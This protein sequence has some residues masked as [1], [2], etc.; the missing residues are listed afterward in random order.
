MPTI[1]AGID[2]VGYGPILGPLVVASSIFL[3]KENPETNMWN[4]LQ[5]SVGKSKKGLENRILVCDSKKAY[6]RQIGLKHLEQTVRAFMS[7]LLPEKVC[8]SSLLPLLSD[9]ALQVTKYPW[10]PSLYASCLSETNRTDFHAL[11][12]NMKHE[13]F[14][15]IDFRSCCIDVR[16]F[17]KLIESTGNKADVVINSVL[18]LIQQI[19]SIAVFCCAKR[20]IIFSDRL[21]GRMYYEEMIN[22]L[23]DVKIIDREE[24]SKNS[25]YKLSVD[26]GKREL[27]IQFEVGA[28]DKHFQVALASMI[29]KYIRE[30]IMVAMNDYFIKLQPGL[31]PT[32]GYWTDGHR[33]LNDLEDKTLEKAGLRKEDIV[34]I[35]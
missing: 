11:T 13:G 1:I 19:I 9:M 10:Y 23:P 26:K 18:K 32:A 33:F 15:F 24:S 35:K 5:E 17:N 16:E 2:E 14:E 20:I 34:R 12:E 28:D 4:R 30:R 6:S 27:D 22:T 7:Q 25:R 29:A 3:V 8:F 21:G 31:K